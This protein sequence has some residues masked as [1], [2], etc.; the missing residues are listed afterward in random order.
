MT[1]PRVAPCVLTILL[2]AFGV[3]SAQPADDIGTI[4][5]VRGNLYR[6]HSGSQVTVFWAGADGIVLL[7]PLNRDFAKFLEAQFAQRFPGRPVKYVVYTGLDF[8]RIGG[9]SIFSATAEVIA[10]ERFNERTF[11]QRRYLPPRF[12]SVDADRNGVLESGELRTLL[13]EPT[14][15]RIAG[16]DGRVAADALWAEVLV[17]E[18]RFGSQRTLS[19]GAAH[20]EL[21]Y[22]GPA[23][24]ADQVLVYFPAE[25][26]LFAPNHPSLTA[27]FSDR[28]V[29]PAAVV[30]WTAT[31]AQID[32]DTLLD[33]RGGTATRADVTSADTYARAMVAGLRDA[34]GQ[35][36]SPA[37]L[38]SGSSI[39]RFEG[40]PFAQVRDA[41]IAALYHR[42]RVLSLDASVAA[43]AARVPTDTQLCNTNA[44][45]ASSGT[46]SGALG[47][48]GFT[49]GRLRGAVEFT[50]APAV[51]TQDSGFTLRMRERHLTVLG[52]FRLL[53]SERVDVT[54]LG[55]V[56]YGTTH[57]NYDAPGTIL[58][59]LSFNESK[60]GWTYGADV[61]AR[62]ADRVALVVP[63]RF[64]QTLD[65][66]GRHNGRGTKAGVGV[67]Y[68]YRRQAM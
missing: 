48:A 42:T 67:V 41:D 9:A 39:A 10:H 18:S 46:G 65:V 36:L 24:G 52:G 13:Q 38:Q 19:I 58:A 51:S 6:A 54:L 21:R 5:P 62:L 2:I 28:T 43:L 12:A 30:Q 34:N 20:I 14:I 64:T 8:D 49:I 1:N 25:R 37:Q 50:T 15:A 26:V 29:N 47:G 53:P 3:A 44:C 16:R 7:D 35:G 61:T 32:F 55:G 45:R 63:L 27:P 31:A 66:L 60:L 59:N 22:A 68:T 57:I 33:G 17:A 23:A 56:T 11:A 40:S 4:T